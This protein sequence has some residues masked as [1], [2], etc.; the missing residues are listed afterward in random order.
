MTVTAAA[1]QSPNIREANASAVVLARDVNQSIFKPTWLLQQGICL[2]REL[3][4]AKAIVFVP[5]VTRIPAPHFELLVVPDRIQLRFDAEQLERESIVA[6]VLGGIARVLSH[7]PYVAVGLN[8]EHVIR[9]ATPQQ[10]GAWN[11]ARFASAWALANTEPTDTRSRFGCS[12]AHDAFNGARMRVRAAVSLDQEAEDSQGAAMDA[13]PYVVRLHCNLHR[14]LPADP[15]PEMIR[16]FSLWPDVEA[17]S[18]KLAEDLS[19]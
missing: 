17:Y 5:G 10:F 8:I 18:R 11:R 4:E 6:R 13:E 15:V 12:F 16:V 7:I 3:D 2:E 14:D 9:A 1:D 19:Q